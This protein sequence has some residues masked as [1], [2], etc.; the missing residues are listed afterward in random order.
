M[1]FR[2]EVYSFGGE[3]GGWEINSVFLFSSKGKWSSKEFD[4]LCRSLCIKLNML[5][6]LS[7]LLFNKNS[8]HM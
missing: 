1:A 3:I 5:F 6:K 2:D 8:E 4:F 7:K